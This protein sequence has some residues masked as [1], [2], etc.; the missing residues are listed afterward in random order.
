MHVL[1]KIL[2]STETFKSLKLIHPEYWLSLMRMLFSS[3][4]S[5]FHEQNLK[6]NQQLLE[7]IPA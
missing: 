1:S 5:L 3:R 2:A 7:P 4:M 6:I